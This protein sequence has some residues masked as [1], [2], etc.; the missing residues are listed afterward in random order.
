MD[1][2]H[3]CTQLHY[4]LEMVELVSASNHGVE[5]VPRIEED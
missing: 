3:H 1:Q 4:I 5:E 2:F